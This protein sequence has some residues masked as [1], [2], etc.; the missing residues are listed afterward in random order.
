MVFEIWVTIEQ[1]YAGI[2]SIVITVGNVQYSVYGKWTFHS[3]K[4]IY[5]S[6]HY[7]DP[8]VA[9]NNQLE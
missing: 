1:I 7:A 9:M 5:T 8:K 2:I 6:M 4:F 3:I